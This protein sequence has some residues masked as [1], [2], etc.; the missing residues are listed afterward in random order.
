MEVTTTS[1]PGAMTGVA[2]KQQLQATCGVA[3][4]T[5]RRTSGSFPKGLKLKYDGILSG[6]PYKKDAPGTYTFAV[7]AR[8]SARPR[9][10]APKILTLDL[11]SP[12]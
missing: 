9:D 5:W 1:M 8:D 10:I 6:V 2:Y 7:V 3:P 11:T 4:Y 12:P